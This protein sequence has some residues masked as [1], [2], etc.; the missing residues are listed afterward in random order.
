M[1]GSDLDNPINT[2]YPLGDPSRYP[3]WVSG[4]LSDHVGLNFTYIREMAAI[5]D[6]PIGGIAEL[7]DAGEGSGPP[8]WVYA[9][10]AAGAGAATFAL[11]AGAW[12]A[13]RRRHSRL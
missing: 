4:R 6:A 9:A 2:V 12:R 10:L 5:S 13:R 3:T 1:N 7:P 8:V 11:A